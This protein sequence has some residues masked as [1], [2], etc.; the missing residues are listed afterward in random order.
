M[1]YKKSGAV[2][3]E[4]SLYVNQ[5]DAGTHRSIRTAL[6]AEKRV[7]TRSS[8]MLGRTERNS[9]TDETRQD[10]PMQS[11]QLSAVFTPGTSGATQLQWI[12]TESPEYSY[13]PWIRNQQ[14]T[15]GGGKLL[16]HTLSC[17]HQQQSAVKERRS[18][19]K[20]AG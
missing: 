4:R 3:R 19:T 7:C 10:R 15:T 2:R 6:G 5:P 9:P 8:L 20:V 14:P 1:Q 13:L 17:E 18:A 12:N 11:L 16:K